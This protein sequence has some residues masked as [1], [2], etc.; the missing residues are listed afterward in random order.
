MIRDPLREVLDAALTTPD[1][2]T[3]DEVAPA[4]VASLR[5]ARRRFGVALPPPFAP[6]PPD[7]A[8]LPIRPGGPTDG[9]AVAAVERR[10]WRQGY[11]GVVS[12]G[13]LDGLDLSYLG[14]YWTGRAAVPPSPRHHLLVAGPPG[15]VHAAIDTGPA[16]HDEVGPAATTTGEVRSLHVD[17]TV[18]GHGVGSALLGAAESALVAAGFTEATLWVVEGHARARRFYERRGWVPDGATQVVMAGPER[19]DEV[20]YRLD[21]PLTAP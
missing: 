20:R 2:A 21:R 12:D 9:A 18:E 15:E 1:D 13:F 7:P 8:G 3:V 14:P 11:R 6:R 17:P 5:L 19:L 4:L 10:A 16:R